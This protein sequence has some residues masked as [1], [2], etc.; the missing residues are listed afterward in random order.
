[1]KV[2]RTGV[3]DEIDRLMDFTLFSVHA[4]GNKMRQFLTIFLMA[5]IIAS[6]ATMVFAQENASNPLAAVSNTDLRI[7]YFDLD[8]SERTDYWVDGAYKVQLLNCSSWLATKY[9]CFK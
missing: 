2:F 8:D 5:I 7:Q 9:V 3:T 4:Y 6:G 1:M